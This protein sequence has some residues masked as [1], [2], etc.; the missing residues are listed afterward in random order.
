MGRVAPKG[1]YTNHV[2]GFILE[3]VTEGLF[4]VVLED[5]SCGKTHT[6]GINR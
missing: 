6:I 4:I 3:G 2:T 1:K 5:K